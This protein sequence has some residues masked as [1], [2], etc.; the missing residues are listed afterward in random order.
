MASFK[1][2]GGK[3]LRGTIYPQGAKNEA[4]QVISAT[5]LT[6][7]KVIIKKVP[8]IKDVIC[9]ME[10]LKGLGVEI[11]NISKNTY[12]FEAKKINLKYLESEFFKEKSQKIRASIM[13]VGPLL[14][15]FGIAKLYPPGG[16]KIGRRRLDT[17]LLGLS[18]LGANFTLKKKSFYKKP[19]KK[20]Y[21][22][23]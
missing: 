23:K 8:L 19:H 14:S 9:L 11:N 7:Q 21:S 13:L 3:Q 22:K 6:S 17:H 20:N 2:T 10:L 12:S 16:D 15:R 18:D 4:L 5:L 1:I